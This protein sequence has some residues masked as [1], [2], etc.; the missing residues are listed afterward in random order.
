[1]KFVQAMSLFLIRHELSYIVLLEEI[2]NHNTFPLLEVSELCFT[3]L[4]NCGGEF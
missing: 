4:N 1:M 3:Q 2:L